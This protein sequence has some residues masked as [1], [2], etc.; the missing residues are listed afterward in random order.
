VGGYG[1]PDKDFPADI[2]AFRGAGSRPPAPPGVGDR[3]PLTRAL[4]YYLPELYPIPGA[5]EFYKSAV[6]AS[7]GA[8]TITPAGLALQLPASSLG[9]VRVFGVGLDDMTQATRVT[10]SLRVNQIPVPAWG[11]FDMFPGVAARV[12]STSDT[13][14]VLPSGCLVDVQ[15]INVDGAAYQVGANYSGWFAPESLIKAWLGQLYNEG[16]R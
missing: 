7:A 8:G 6:A 5:T 12:T 11:A 16:Q 9:I 15:V 10:F 3:P 2:G 14:I 1:R 4:Q 13:W